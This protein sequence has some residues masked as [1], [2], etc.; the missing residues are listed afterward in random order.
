MDY[1]VNAKVVFIDYGQLFLRAKARACMRLGTDDSDYCVKRNGIDVIEREKD[2]ENETKDGETRIV[3]VGRDEEKRRG[4]KDPA[5]LI[6]NV[7]N[8]EQR[9]TD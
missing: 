9:W 5:S 6:V 8:G 1:V 3:E 7:V 2:S 4:R